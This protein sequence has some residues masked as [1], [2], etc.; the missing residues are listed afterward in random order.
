MI[1]GLEHRQRPLHLHG[2]PC[3]YKEAS[4]SPVVSRPDPELKCSEEGGG[5][6]TRLL[7]C[8]C[9]G[10]FVIFFNLFDFL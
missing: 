1:M 2:D 4:G 8:L 9:L 7:N 3:S 10:L 5:L 6:P